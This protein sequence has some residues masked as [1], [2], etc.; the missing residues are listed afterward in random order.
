M[1]EVA[2]TGPLL[3]GLQLANQNNNNNGT[4]IVRPRVAEA[5]YLKN[6]KEPRNREEA[7]LEPLEAI[8]GEIPGGMI[9]MKQQSKTAGCLNELRPAYHHSDTQNSRTT[10]L[11]RSPVMGRNSNDKCG[12]AG[13]ASAGTF[14]APKQITELDFQRRKLDQ[15]CKTAGLLLYR[16]CL[17]PFIKTLQAHGILINF[18]FVFIAL[19]TS[20]FLNGRAVS[21]RFVRAVAVSMPFLNNLSLWNVHVLSTTSSP[22]ESKSLSPSDAE[23]KSTRCRSVQATQTHV[24]A[25]TEAQIKVFKSD[26]YLLIPDALTASESGAL[27]DEAQEVIRTVTKGEDGITEYDG[28]DES[29]IQQL[30]PVGSVLATFEPGEFDLSSCNPTF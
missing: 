22:D 16:M 19:L 8:N 1:A 20:E 23:L 27:L 29:T 13:G 4:V 3:L 25:L 15:Q 6:R 30:S 14:I 18:K 2:G 7:G 12:N 5:T 26:G 24:P 21:P 17:L 10:P 28:S 11:V 9:D